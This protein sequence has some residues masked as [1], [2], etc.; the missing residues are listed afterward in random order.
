MKKIFVVLA[1]FISVFAYSQNRLTYDI[2]MGY[3]GN[4]SITFQMGFKN[5][6]YNFGLY[7]GTRG[8]NITSEASDS[9]VDYRSIADKTIVLSSANR[10]LGTYGFILG[11]NYNVKN[12]GFTL[13]VGGGFANKMTEHTIDYE[14]D[15]NF[16]SNE[17]NTKYSYST[18]PMPSY[19]AILEYDFANKNKKS[20]VGIGLQ[21]GFN[22]VNGIIGQVM[23]VIYFDKL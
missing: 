23:M 4:Q 14:Y 11:T 2:G 19:E 5:I 17:Y 22:N 15:F 9:R 12:T 20:A 7:F 6:A 21:T 3:S 8:V 16:T 10:D 1:V 18:E 13:A